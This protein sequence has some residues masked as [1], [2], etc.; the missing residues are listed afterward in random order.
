MGSQRFAHGREAFPELCLRSPV[1][2][3]CSQVCK[4]PPTQTKKLTRTH[5]GELALNQYISNTALITYKPL[6]TVEAESSA[7]LGRLGGALRGSAAAASPARVA[8][9]IR[10]YL[11]NKVGSLQLRDTG[12]ELPIEVPPKDDA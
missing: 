10:G 4:Y 2:A 5:H 11:S 3:R 9:S 6:S 12:S 1:R 7:L 8:S